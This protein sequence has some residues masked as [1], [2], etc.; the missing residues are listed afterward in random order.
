MKEMNEFIKKSE[1]DKG[2]FNTELTSNE[3]DMITDLQECKKLLQAKRREIQD[4]LRNLNFDKEML[5]WAPLFSGMSAIAC[6]FGSIENPI[7]LPFYYF[8]LGANVL[9]IIMYHLDAK[10]KYKC[11]K[12][13]RVVLKALIKKRDMLQEEAHRDFLRSEMSPLVL[14]RPTNELS[15]NVQ[16][17]N[18][19]KPLSYPEKAVARHGMIVLCDSKGNPLSEKGEQLVKRYR[20]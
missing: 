3:R 7:V 14:N 16:I 15:D 11:V 9:G 20:R 10:K 19:D 17:L 1:R 8:V 13:Q 6:Y 4:N 12:N 18:N 2:V 5:K